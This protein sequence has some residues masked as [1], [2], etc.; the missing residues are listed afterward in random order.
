MAAGR[1]AGRGEPPQAEAQTSRPDGGST[2][3]NRGTRLP[4]WRE[5]VVAPQAPDTDRRI[6][7]RL[8]DAELKAPR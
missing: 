4:P 8:E 2:R 6:D 3:T 5:S 1:K 7:L